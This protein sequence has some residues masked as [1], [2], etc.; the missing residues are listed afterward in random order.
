MAQGSPKASMPLAI[1]ERYMLQ[2]TYAPMPHSAP[3]PGPLAQACRW[4]GAGRVRTDTQ[5]LYRMR[6][7]VG[8]NLK[9]MKWAPGHRM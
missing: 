4:Q 9:L 2:T 6:C 5:L 1:R 3:C 7:S 8:T